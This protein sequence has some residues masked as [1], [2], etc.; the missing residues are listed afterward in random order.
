MPQQQSIIDRKKGEDN[1]RE[2]IK[3]LYGSSLDL[4]LCKLS[5]RRLFEK[6]VGIWL[7]TPKKL[8]GDSK[9]L[10]LT[11]L[12]LVLALWLYKNMLSFKKKCMLM[13]GEIIWLGFVVKYFI[14][15]KIEKRDRWRKCGKILIVDESWWWDTLVSII[16]CSQ[17]LCTFENL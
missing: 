17:F 4:N 11:L 14:K 15:R 1:L 12:G 7:A 3:C 2:I 6:I 8:L 5:L 9:K 16:V 13:R 10:L